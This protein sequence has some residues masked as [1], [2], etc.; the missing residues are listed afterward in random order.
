MC[1]IKCVMM[2]SQTGLGEGTSTAHAAQPPAASRASFN[3][4]TGHAIPTHGRLGGSFSSRF[5]LR[6]IL[7]LTGPAPAPTGSISNAHAGIG[8]ATPRCGGLR[9]ASR[10]EV[11]VQGQDPLAVE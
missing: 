2:G 5:C 9:E 3:Q 1:S 4:I 10:E 7:P 11:T 8:A 6:L